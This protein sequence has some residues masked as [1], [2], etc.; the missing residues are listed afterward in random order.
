MG[1]VTWLGGVNYFRNLFSALHGLDDKKIR[2]VVFA[3]LKSDVS[4][5]AELAEI[6]RTPLLDRRSVTWTLHKILGRIQPGQDVLLGRLFRKHRVDL[7]FHFGTNWRCTTVP[8]IGWIPDFQ[9]LYYPKFFS[10]KEYLGR[11]AQFDNIVE[12][13]DALLL[14]SEDARN[15]L[16]EKYP[17]CGKPS[18]VLRFVSSLCPNIAALP[19]REEL[20]HKYRLSEPWFHVPNQFWTHKNHQVIV[21]ALNIL[22]SSGRCPLV[23]STGKTDDYRNVGYFP[24]LMQKTRDY[25][26]EDRFRPLGIVPYEDVVALMLYS[27]AVINPSLFEGWSTSVEESKAMGKKVLLSDIPVHREQAPRRGQ[28]FPPHDAAALAALLFAAV[29]DHSAVDEKKLFHAAQQGLPSR[30]REFAMN[31][32]SICASTLAQTN[33]AL[34][35]GKQVS[36]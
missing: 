11:D 16:R 34:A 36:T 23:I 14:S 30:R 32:E 9:H 5:F 35:L 27:V 21:D 10:E 25:G 1:Q 17:R 29:D 26:L 20:M 6:V 3:G 31:F 7:V 13:C 24:A 12:R 33:S 18:H 28:Y 15:D 4:D 8:A 22:Q 2:P 19:G